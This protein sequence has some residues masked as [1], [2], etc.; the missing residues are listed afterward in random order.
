MSLPPSSTQRAILGS[1]S[2]TSA[3]TTTE[4]TL[5]KVPTGT[6]TGDS[7][8]VG[9]IGRRVGS[10]EYL[11]RLTLDGNGNTR[12]WLLRDTVGMTSVVVPGTITADT[13]Y[14]LAIN[15]TGTNPVTV[16][17]KVWKSSDGEP[18]AWQVTKT[19]TGTTA[20]TLNLQTAGSVGIY[21]Y[22]NSG[23]SNVTSTSPLK[24]TFDSYTAQ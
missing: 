23:S 12:L 13:P 3:T 7:L 18:A 21:G 10:D 4:F 24:L 15:V 19:D 1:V 14:T 11:A 8:Y 17:A 9:L 20:A 22:M 16:S 2:S 5:D 6:G